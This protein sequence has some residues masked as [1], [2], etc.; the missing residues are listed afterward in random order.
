MRMRFQILAIAMLACTAIRSATGAGFQVETNVLGTYTGIG[1]PIQIEV[2]SGAQ[3][4][5]ANTSV[6][7]PIDQSIEGG[8]VVYEN[9]G[10]FQLSATATLGRL[11]ALATAMLTSTETPFTPDGASNGGLV[12]AT[13]NANFQDLLTV[14]G[15]LPPGTPVPITIG[16][17]LDATATSDVASD[18]EAPEPYAPT[19][20]LLFLDFAEEPPLSVR[21]GGCDD[22]E[23]VASATF[24]T[25]IGA[26]FSI[27][28]LLSAG[29]DFGTNSDV[30]ADNAHF[31]TTDAA[32]TGIV[33]LSSTEPGVGVSSEGGAVYPAPE[34]GSVAGAIAGIGAVATL[35]RV[36]ERNRS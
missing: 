8:G 9:G 20:A 30:L 21:L 17:H 23:P 7:Q 29:I 11:S 10:E 15:P 6:T 28:A 4:A 25:T 1:A 2:A 16:I 36:R 35:R 18:C 3:P 5:T 13:A 26:L 33:F 32:H 14:T 27:E 12:S 22:T 24:Q 19:G 34:S 31:A